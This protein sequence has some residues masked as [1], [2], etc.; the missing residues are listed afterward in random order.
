M[1]HN[2]IENHPFADVLSPEKMDLAIADFNDH[3][4]DQKI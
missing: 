2:E 1:T 3:G 4:F